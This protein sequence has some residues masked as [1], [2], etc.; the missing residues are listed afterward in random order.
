MHVGEGLYLGIS[1]ASHPK[2]AE[3]HHA[4]ILRVLLC[5]WLHPLTQNEQIR[6]GNI[7]E[8]FRWSTPLHLHKCIARYVSGSWVSCSRQSWFLTTCRRLE[9]LVYLSFLTQVF[10]PWWCE[11]C[12]VIQ[13]QFWMKECNILGGQNILLP[14]LHIFG[15]GGQHPL[16]LQDLRPWR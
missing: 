13:Q 12:R 7:G 14:L 1:L 11:T 9:K 16:N 6:H 3:F 15:G 2:T 8:V 4:P 5:F 10:H